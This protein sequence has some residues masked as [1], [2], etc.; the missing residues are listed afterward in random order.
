M[1]LQV[2]E[3]N[4]L[5]PPVRTNFV[6][7]VELEAVLAYLTLTGAVVGELPA[8]A[9]GADAVADDRGVTDAEVPHGLSVPRPFDDFDGDA[10][11]DDDPALEP[12]SRS[13]EHLGDHPGALDVPF[14]DGE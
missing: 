3:G 13:G 2:R 9:M 1:R 4:R 10:D 14:G 8:V 11:F 7:D 12:A 5:M 6:T